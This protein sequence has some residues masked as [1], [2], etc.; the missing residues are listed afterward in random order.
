MQRA[1]DRSGG[2]YARA[3]RVWLTVLLA[4]VSGALVLGAI[5]FSGSGVFGIALVVVGLWL[6]LRRG[7]RRVKRARQDSNLRPSVP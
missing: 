3:R 4:F 2:A 6:A 7:G 5:G 1:A